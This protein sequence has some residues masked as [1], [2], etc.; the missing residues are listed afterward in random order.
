MC[1][2][3]SGG[4]DHESLPGVRVCDVGW[5]ASG[6]CRVYER[7][8]QSAP[9]D[10]L[11]CEDEEALRRVRPSGEEAEGGDL[12]ERHPTCEEGRASGHHQDFRDGAGFRGFHLCDND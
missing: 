4:H 11:G 8:E 3:L 2:P 6:G 12:G 1:K 5:L 10:D 9:I 7:A